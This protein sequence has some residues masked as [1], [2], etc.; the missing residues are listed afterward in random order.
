MEEVKMEETPLI[1]LNLNPYN[2]WEQTINIR[3]EELAK[4]LI[5]D[6]NENDKCL[7]LTSTN[8]KEVHVYIMMK[9]WHILSGS[10]IFLDYT[11]SKKKDKTIVEMHMS[12]QNPEFIDP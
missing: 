7:I 1:T 8:T 10:G 2:K 9:V 4:E 5:E 11:I 6:Y 12:E 3:A